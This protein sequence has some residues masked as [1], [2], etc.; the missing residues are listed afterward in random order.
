MYLWF[1]Q[2]VKKRV[3]AKYDKEIIKRSDLKV[4]D[5]VKLSDLDVKDNECSNAIINMIPK[6]PS[7]SVSGPD[8]LGD[9]LSMRETY[10]IFPALW[11]TADYDIADVLSQKISGVLDLS[12]NIVK[13]VA[14]NVISSP[15][16]KLMMGCGNLFLFKKVA[17]YQKSDL[18]PI[19]ERYQYNEK[20]AYDLSENLRVVDFNLPS[21]AT[22]GVAEKTTIVYKRIGKGTLDGFIL[23][24]TYVNKKTGQL[25]QVANLPSFAVSRPTEWTQER[26]YIENVDVALPSYLP[27]GEYDAF[28]SLTNRIKAR[29][30][31]LGDLLVD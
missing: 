21:Q 25:Y 15:N 22:R 2:A 8:N 29:S 24:M 4:G 17:P 18:L 30:L 3:Y 13:D 6:D 31:Y 19:Q 11:D 23:Y 12:V 5:I 10:A 1:T 14:E 20:Y 7:I 28:I 26:Y 16:Y 9:H 27:T